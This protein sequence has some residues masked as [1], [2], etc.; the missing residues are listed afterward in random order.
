MCYEEKVEN[1]LRPVIA[2]EFPAA[3]GGAPARGE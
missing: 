3:D 1:D 2:K